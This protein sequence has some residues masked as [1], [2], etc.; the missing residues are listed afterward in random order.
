MTEA[1]T[2]NHSPGCSRQEVALTRLAQADVVFSQGCLHPILSF[3]W[4][5]GLTELL[6]SW[7]S[8]SQQWH[9]KLSLRI[10]SAAA[11][12][13]LQLPFVSSSS[14]SSSSTLDVRIEYL[15]A[16]S[17]LRSDLARSVPPHFNTSAPTAEFQFQCSKTGGPKARSSDCNHSYWYSRVDNSHLKHRPF[18][19]INSAAYTRASSR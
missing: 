10:F 5:C 6:R 13:D 12:P 7:A 15:P 3:A 8:S 17:L 14:P 16:A 1:M 18:H 4:R 11:L 9:P 2:S 19:R